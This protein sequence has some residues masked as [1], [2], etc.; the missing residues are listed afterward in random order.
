MP[1][2]YEQPYSSRHVIADTRDSI[3][4]ED[5]SYIRNFPRFLHILYRKQT[6][7]NSTIL[8]TT[9]HATKSINRKSSSAKSPDIRRPATPTEA[10]NTAS[11][12]QQQQQQG[13]ISLTQANQ[14]SAQ[15][16]QQPPQQP[17]FK[18]LG[19]ANKSPTQMS[20][21]PSDFEHIFHYSETQ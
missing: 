21:M 17:G 2:R 9:R 16:Q 3:R 15:Q 19:Q 1:R 5:P 13:Q 18:T 12:R 10:S 20:A 14:T 4:S 7:F 8:A 11:L 6:P